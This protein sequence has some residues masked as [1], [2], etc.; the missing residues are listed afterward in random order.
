[1]KLDLEKIEKKAIATGTRVR[2]EELTSRIPI[3]RVYSER[4]D[5]PLKNLVAC[6]VAHEARQNK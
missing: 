6:I 2:T 3:G 5:D 1:M 4:T